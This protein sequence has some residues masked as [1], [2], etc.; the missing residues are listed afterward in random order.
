MTRQKSQL[1]ECGNLSAH[2][3]TK[4]KHEFPISEMKLK[5]S[6]EHIA[7]KRRQGESSQIDFTNENFQKDRYDSNTKL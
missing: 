7:I 5:L 6:Q 2:C 3:K 1:P 4:E